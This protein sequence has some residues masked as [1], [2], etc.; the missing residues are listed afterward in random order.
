VADPLRPVCT[1]WIAK[2][3]LAWEMKK[4]QFQEEADEAMNFFNGPYDWLYGAKNPRAASGFAY[5]GDDGDLPRPTFAMTVNKVA[6]LVQLF[7]PALYHRNPVR[8]VTPRK[9]PLL[10]I[11]TFGDPNDPQVQQMYI[12]MGQLVKQERQ[13]DASRAA[14]LE[15]YLNYTPAALDLKTESRWAIDEAVI[16]G[17]GV[18]WTE[19]YTPAGGGG[20][21]MVGSFFDTVDN[22]LIDPDMETLRE[23]QWVAR[24]CIHPYWKVEAEYGLPAGTL[25]KWASLESYNNQGVIEAHPDGDYRRKQGLTSDLIVY[26]K[27]Y[28]KMGLG[29]RL[30]G[31]RDDLR[32]ALDQYGDFV[33]LVVCDNCP[34]PLNVPQELVE[35]A[36]GDDAT[37][38]L[39]ASAGIGGQGPNPM[40]QQ[41]LQWPT[42]YWADDSWPF[43]PISFHDVPRRVWPM[44]HIA[45][46]MGEL[47][48]LN[49]AWS[50]LAGKVRTAS[51]DFICIAKSAGEELK[52]RIKTGPDYT[53]IEVEAIHESIDK[54]VKFLQHPE[55]TPEIYKIIQGVTDNF[56]KRTGLTELMYGLSAKQMRSAQ[57]AE[58]KGEQ[59][60]IRPDDMANKVEDAM[61][62]LSRQEALTARWHL[63]GSDVQAPLG[64][65]GA[66]WWQ[67]LVVPSDPTEILHQLEYRI[68]AGSAKKPNQARD[69]SNM[70]QAMTTLFP[71]L[72]GFA[73]QSGQVNQV[74]A[75]LTAW[76]KSID[77]DATAF[78]LPQPPPPQPAPA[79]GMAPQ[80]GGA[81]GAPPPGPPPQRNGTP[82]Q[83][84]QPAGQPGLP[85]R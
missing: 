56:E 63:Q 24:R 17:M 74:N 14:L 68:E 82:P 16:K 50:F 83:Q 37:Q 57:E 38:A 44:S 27:I 55:F 73:M 70:Q 69:Q 61:S 52:D 76:A 39:S 54:V 62:L 47:K 43:T 32:P 31:M 13:Q 5:G 25:K 53:I 79:P 18:L 10:P 40:V 77:L 80:A 28:S 1:Q 48:F 33:Y 45:P 7:G 46:A 3:H 66:Q 64:P 34:F 78:L 20:A 58:V 4:K 6:E 42:P 49:W 35:Q 30:S 84:P 41:R 2:I 26:W 15:A 75:L 8:K 81:P 72:W 59:L 21:K 85:M 67:Q 11:E 36:F 60:T 12:Q 23:S 51:R 65:M 29:G 19:L 9:P 22:L 71:S